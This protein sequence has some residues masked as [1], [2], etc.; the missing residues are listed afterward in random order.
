MR[1]RFLFSSSD[2]DIRVDEALLSR[3]FLLNPCEE[4]PSLRLSDYFEAI[5]HFLFVKRCDSLMD[6]LGRLWNRPVQV[7]DIEEVLIRSEKHGTLYHLASAEIFGLGCKAKF[8]V[9]GAVS[10]TNQAWLFREF[11]TLK[12]LNETFRLPY[13]PEAHFLETLEWTTPGDPVPLSF[14]LSEWFE[15]YHEWHLSRG[16]AGEPYLVIWDL[17]NGYRRATDW[18]GYEIYRSVSRILTQG[19]SW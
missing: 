19:T 16:D 1:V 4:H 13:L 12:H 10:E 2:G 11:E 17:Q 18:E 15:N 8:A 3:P 9:S 14:M 5:E 6:L 7:G